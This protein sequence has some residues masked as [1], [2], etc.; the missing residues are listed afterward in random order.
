ML[1]KNL[2][3]CLLRGA[4]TPGDQALVTE[5]FNTHMTSDDFPQRL[6]Q[7]REAMPKAFPKKLRTGPLIVDQNIHGHWRVQSQ[8]AK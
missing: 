5:F 1:W 4:Q 8:E 3:P 6:A 7:L 2:I